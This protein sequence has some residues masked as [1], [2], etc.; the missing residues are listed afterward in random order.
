MRYTVVWRPSAEAELAEIWVTGPDRQSVRSA[1][2]EIDAR[3]RSRPLD[4]GESRQG[5]FRVLLT[6]PI[7]VVYSV[8][9]EDAM[10]VVVEV[11]RTSNQSDASSS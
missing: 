8:N 3:L 6:P 4:A 1:A 10:V 11:W 7:G 2:D 5:E 9:E